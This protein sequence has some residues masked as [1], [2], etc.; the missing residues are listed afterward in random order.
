MAG[1][2]SVDELRERL[3]RMTPEQVRHVVR[4]GKLHAKLVKQKRKAH[5]LT[6]TQAKVLAKIEKNGILG[7]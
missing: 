4:M 7:A 2:V 3:K 5:G 1:L 6:A